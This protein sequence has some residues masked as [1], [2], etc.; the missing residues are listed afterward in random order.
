MYTTSKLSIVVPISE[1]FDDVEKVYTEYK[2]SLKS[3]ASDYEFIYVLDGEFK[4]VLETLRQL[5][6]KGERINIICLARRFGESAALTAGFEQCDGDFILTLPAYMQV[7][8]S[9]LD[10][11]FKSIEDCDVVVVRRW[12]RVDPMLNRIQASIFSGLQRFIT[13]SSFHDLGCGLRLLRTYVTNEVQVYGDQHRFFPILADI[14]GF[15][16]KE[17]ELPQ[18]QQESHYRI[19]GPGIYLRRLL[20]LATVFFLTKFTKK[21]LRFFGLLGSGSFLTGLVFLIYITIERFWF[22]KALADRPALLLST[23][24]VVLGVQI[25]AL[26]L[27][28][29]LIIFAHTKNIKEYKIK[30]IIN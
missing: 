13:K 26:G 5:Q 6:I 12:P 24:L 25:F 22:G 9:K 29:E 21:P 7:E 11:I 14:K 27:I 3:I 30:E 18:S 20:D 23:L 10:K 1:R 16:V 8:L 2:S 15:K 19:Y 4:D 28:G 17:V